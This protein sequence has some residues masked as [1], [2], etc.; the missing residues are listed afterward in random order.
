MTSL[1][2]YDELID[3][4]RLARTSGVG[5][6]K[7]RQLL[8]RFGAASEAIAHQAEWGGKQMAVSKPSVAEEEFAAATKAK[9]APAPVVEEDTAPEP[10]V[11]KTAP[12]ATAVPAGKAS[13]ADIVSDWD[14]E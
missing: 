11:R 13:L 1:L 8:T 7:F 14:D 4:I 9:P 6:K 5:A 3:W 10:E 2:P 12:K